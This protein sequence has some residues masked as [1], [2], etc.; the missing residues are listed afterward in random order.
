V[1][2]SSPAVSSART[3]AAD[4][5]DRARERRV[6]AVLLGLRPD[7]LVD[8]S[9]LVLGATAAIAVC[10]MILPGVSGSFLL[11]VLG[12]TS[13]SSPRSPPATARRSRWSSAGH[14]VGLASVR[15]AARLAARRAHD[16][17]LAAADRPHGRLRARAVAVALWSGVGD[18]T[19]GAPDGR[20]GARRSVR[21]R[22]PS[23]WLAVVAVDRRVALSRAAGPC[24]A[25]AL[26][27][28]HRRSAAVDVGDERETEPALAARTER[29]ARG[30]D[31][32]LREQRLA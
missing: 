20:A 23:R 17:V 22:S 30:D 29:A 7:A 10:A 28:V 16:L 14:V 27:R 6:T 8:P 1:R 11:L 18:P 3:D 12:C 15:D 2:P 26:Q 9:P 5:R 19:L 25:A 32:P 21:S 31:D 13:R 24:A 4:R